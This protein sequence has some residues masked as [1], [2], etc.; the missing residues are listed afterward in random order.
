VRRREGRLKGEKTF[1][2]KGEA[3]NCAGEG[4]GEDGKNRD[5]R[6]LN[7]PQDFEPARRMRSESP[8]I[9]SEF[10]PG[11][12]RQHMLHKRPNIELQYFPV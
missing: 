11:Q 10:Y 7:K 1:L 12:Q 5:S 9:L 6:N 3:K 8:A 2:E 4:D